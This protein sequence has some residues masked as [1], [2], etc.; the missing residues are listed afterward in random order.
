[1]LKFTIES[2]LHRKPSIFS[3]RPQH[4]IDRGALFVQILQKS[5]QCRIIHVTYK[6]MDRCYMCVSGE[7]KCGQHAGSHNRFLISEFD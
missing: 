6:V 7:L 5:I 4:Y 2:V 1:M 3:G